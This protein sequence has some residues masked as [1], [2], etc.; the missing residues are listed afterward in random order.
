MDVGRRKLANSAAASGLMEQIMF[1]PRFSIVMSPA[2][3]SSLRWKLRVDEFFSVPKTWQHTSPT[4]G[5][6]TGRTSPD[7]ST[8]TAQ[9]QD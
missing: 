4:V 6:S 9:Q 2:L 1:L 8:A 5:P 3:R 7:S